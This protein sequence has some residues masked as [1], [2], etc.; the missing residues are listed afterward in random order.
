MMK[1]GRW[2]AIRRPRFFWMTWRD[3]SPRRM[4]LI[5]FYRDTSDL[6][7]LKIYRQ[8]IRCVT[9]HDGGVCASLALCPTASDA[10][11]AFCCIIF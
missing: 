5:S 8:R 2:R 11:D 1:D 10:K 4:V 3:A 7:Q 6:V 9:T